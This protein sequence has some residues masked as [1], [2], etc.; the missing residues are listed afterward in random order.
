MNLK[1]KNNIYGKRRYNE[2]YKQQK[3]DLNLKKKKENKKDEIFQLNIKNL[4]LYK[5]IKKIKKEISPTNIYLC[6]VF[7]DYLNYQIF[8][9]L[10]T[11]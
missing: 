8:N 7:P 10:V 1:Q 3:T 11:K 2:L 5:D 9:F 6:E 4:N